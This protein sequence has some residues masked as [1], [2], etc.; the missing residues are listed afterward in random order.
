MG[1]TGR[2]VWRAMDEL[3]PSKLGPG[4]LD[5]SKLGPVSWFGSAIL[6][7][8][9]LQKPSDIGIGRGQAGQLLCIGDR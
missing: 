1:G 2:A 3:G 9:V 5:S 7:L 8:K 6:A 4:E